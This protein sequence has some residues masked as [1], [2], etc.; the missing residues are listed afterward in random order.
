MSLSRL[1]TVLA[2]VVLVG[3][4]AYYVSGRGG[5]P[6]IEIVQPRKF[7]GRSGTLDII[8][9]TPAGQLSSATITLEQG[10]KS[11]S[12]FSLGPDA[13][14]EVNQESADRIRIRRP[15]GKDSVPELQEG[16]AELVVTA[17]RP[18]F[19][20]WRSLESRATQALSVRL[21]P[22]RV[23]IVSTHHHVN[24]G[25]SEMV[26][27]RVTPADAE[28]GV[29]VG[30]VRYPGYAAKGTGLAS[31]PSLRVAFFALLPDQDLT[32]PISLYAR[33]EAG[34]E[35]TATFEY[36][37]FPKPFNRSRIE[38]D[39]RFLQRVVPA[40]AQTAPELELST[41][42]ADD[43]LSAFLKIN[44][45]L[46]RMNAETIAGLAGKASAEVLWRGPFQ[47]LGNSQVESMFADHRSYF[48]Q[49][50]EVD[51]QV[52]LGFDLAVT[53]NVP[54]AAANAGAVVFADDLGIYGNAVILD[55]GLGV[56]SLYAHLSSIDVSVGD[57]VEKGQTL[58][59]SG[60]SGLA[61]GD[62]LHFSMLVQGHPVNPVEWWDAHWIEDRV[63]RKLR[64]AGQT[65]ESA[66]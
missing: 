49:G 35:G 42:S 27:Y 56:Q 34:N 4:A 33:D 14:G 30:D 5:N 38:L 39:D 18:V 53:A 36:Q 60:M 31:D 19:F 57:R 8:V 51:Q 45:D 46:R 26:V 62:H 9:D 28:S 23:G 54:V 58:G 11:R 65:K 10:G 59:R 32:T 52:H 55:H 50:R 43:L 13:E 48:Y 15:L 41:G 66:R 44:G 25:G 24:H 12:L 61:G 3:G 2:V 7:V 17:A 6:K 37:V 1:F 63:T 21:T 20:G 16:P 40:I 64:E 29:A 22:P 47:Q